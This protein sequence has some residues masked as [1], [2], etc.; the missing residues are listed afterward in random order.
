MGNIKFEGSS[1]YALP[2]ALTAQKDGVALGFARQKSP[3]IFGAR[4]R[5]GVHAYPGTLPGTAEATP[6]RPR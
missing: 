6:V 1:P 4:P 2:I 5:D 3:T